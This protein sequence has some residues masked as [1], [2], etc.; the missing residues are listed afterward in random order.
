MWP[1]RKPDII[2]ATISPQQLTLSW[3]KKN[4]SKIEVKNHKNFDFKNLEFEKSIVFN[5]TKISSLVQQFAQ[6]NN[7]KKATC[8]M[9][10]SGPTIF[11]KILTLST[12]TPAIQDLQIKDLKHL[13]WNYTYLGPSAKNGFEFYIC[14]I[15]REILFQYKLLGITSGINPA[16][17]TTE[18]NAHIELYKH[19]NRKNFRHSQLLLD[20]QSHNYDMHTFFTP[21][22]IS[23]HVE[24]SDTFSATKNHALAT[25][26]GLFLLG[27][28]I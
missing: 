22:I 18:K 2:T 28:K 14:G 7:L 20:M 5:P 1:F 16:V 8:A 10:V 6:E 12:A 9:A 23:E 19:L 17:I 25:N 11:E 27:T 4:K 13:K 15:K 3:I 26:I 24:L 21:E